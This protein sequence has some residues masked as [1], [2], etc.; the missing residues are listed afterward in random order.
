MEITYATTADIEVI[1]ELDVHISKKELTKAMNEKRIIVLKDNDKLCGWLRYNLFWDSI[2]FL[3]MIYVL[4]EY[5]NQKIGKSLLLFWEKKMK[6]KAY[7]FVLT[8]SLSTEEAQHF[9]R[10]LGYRDCGNLI[11]PNQASETFF[12]KTL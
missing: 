8:S 12:I 7:D 4:Y 1:T 9:Y 11:L 10:K 2:P 3:N 5:R 6:S